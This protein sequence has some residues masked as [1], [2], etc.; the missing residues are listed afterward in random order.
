MFI[1][2]KII[3]LIRKLINKKNGKNKRKKWRKWKKWRYLFK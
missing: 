2:T 3:L 1:T